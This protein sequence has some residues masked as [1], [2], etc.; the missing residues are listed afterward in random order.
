MD[1]FGKKKNIVAISPKEV[2]TQF[3]AQD[4]LLK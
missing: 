4:I 2:K 3:L 1:L